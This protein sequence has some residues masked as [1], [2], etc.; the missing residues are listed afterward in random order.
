MLTAVPGLLFALLM[1]FFWVG[2]V[3][4]HAQRGGGNFALL[5]LA[6]FP[7]YLVIF[8]GS[9]RRAHDPPPTP[10]DIRLRAGMPAPLLIFFGF[11]ALFFV[12]GWLG[13]PGEDSPVA[14]NDKAT[15]G[16]TNS[17]R[18]LSTKPG[19]TL[20]VIVYD[21]YCE[22]APERTVNVSVQREM[23]ADGPGNVFIA[24]IPDGTSARSLDVMALLGVGNNIE[25]VYD[26]ALRVTRRV[27]TLG[28]AAI[29]FTPSASSSR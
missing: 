15:T 2:G 19:G 9:F 23:E 24:E 22:K 8:A 4:W 26:R 17:P 25:V 10:S 3:S 5:H 27:S 18:D 16:C 21:R 7:F 11:I 13:D 6:F 12:V 28:E 1:L 20:Y 29:R 14:R